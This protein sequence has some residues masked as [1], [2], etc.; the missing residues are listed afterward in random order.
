MILKKVAIN[1]FKSFE[2]E[3]IILHN[4]NVLVGKN[5]SGKSNFIQALDLF[6]N[7]RKKFYNKDLNQCLF[8]NMSNRSTKL[9]FMIECTFKLGKKEEISIRQTR[10]REDKKNIKIEN[11]NKEVRI[12]FVHLKTRERRLSSDYYEIYNFDKKKFIRLSIFDFSRA[13][14]NLS[15]IY[16]PAVRSL[17]GTK[18]MDDIFPALLSRVSSVRKNRLFKSVDNVKDIIN[19][20]LLNNFE[21]NFNNLIKKDFFGELKVSFS[22]DSKNDEFVQKVLE[23]LIPLANDGIETEVDEKGSGL[24]SYIII[25]LYNYLA[26]LS[27]KSL[28]LALEEPE[29]HLHPSAQKNLLKGITQIFKSQKNQILTTT[30]SPFLI[31]SSELSSLIYFRRDKNIKLLKS[32]IAQVKENQLTTYNL[33][34][35]ERNF[36][37]EKKDI[38]FADKVILSEGSSDKLVFKHLFS[39][40]DI[41]LDLKNISV[42]EY[43]GTPNVKH[44]LKLIIDFKIPYF[45]IFDK[46][47][48]FSKDQNGRIYYGFFNLLQYLGIR[49]TPFEKKKILD[50][51][52]NTQSLNKI[53]IKYNCSSMKKGLEDDLMTKN[54]LSYF[55]EILGDRSLTLKR[56]KNERYRRNE[57]KRTIQLIA[58]AIENKTEIPHSFQVLIKQTIKTL[59]IK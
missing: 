48:I 54:T 4:V 46:D 59:K 8:K 24:Q 21:Y 39:L 55:R 13:F 5:N 31:N 27:K 56:I 41:N 10:D 29:A 3:K 44:L 32:S 53:L 50:K 51:W 26:Q 36:R 42:I 7:S 43:G 9:K 12:R 47:F 22:F 37:V 34:Y 52:N 17:K 58:Y 49:I 16:I 11:S 28:I 35:L 45:L 33:P 15:F 57:I 30:H 18:I 6:F 20:N 25:W 40:Y 2:K 19:S 23:T 38:F 14:R 1:N